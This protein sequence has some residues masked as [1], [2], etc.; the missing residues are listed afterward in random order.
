M[1]LKTLRN[2]VK[3]PSEIR[4]YNPI[5]RYLYV[6]EFISGFSPFNFVSIG[7]HC[8]GFLVCNFLNLDYIPDSRNV[9][10]S[11]L[12]QQNVLISIISI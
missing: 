9:Q 3:C 5:I 12:Y 2:K 4:K 11:V 10:F 1:R 7:K 6:D 8:C